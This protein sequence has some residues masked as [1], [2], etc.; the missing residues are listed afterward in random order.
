MTMS[1]Y[2]NKNE[3]LG[4]N[5][6]FNFIT[7]ARGIGKTYQFKQWAIADHIRTGATCWWVMRYQTEIDT[8]IKDGRFFADILDRFPGHVFK[9]DGSVGYIGEGD[10]PKETVWVPFITFKALSE[11]AIKAISDPQCNKMVFDEFIPLPGIRYLKNE[12]ERFLELY[13]TISRGRDL[14]TFFLANN[15]TSVCP[16][17]TYFK[18]KP[19]A[20]E[21]TI[22][23]DICIQNA[24]TQA[25]TE[26]MRETRFGKLVKGTHYADY[27]IENQSLADTDAFVLPMPPRHN[28]IFTIKTEYGLF[29]GY[30]C[31]P[32]MLYIKKAAGE[33]A[34]YVYVFDSTLH[35]DKTLLDF[36]GKYVIDVIRSYYSRGLI[37]FPNVRD[38]SEFFQSTAKYLKI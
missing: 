7:G 38:K 20:A 10:N 15:V 5:K 37:G 25:F 19:S 17:Y 23:G 14:R 1:K 29:N 18:V 24:R 34:D 26:S 4:Y 6:L 13:F 22:S 31:S 3:L 21:F 9:I 33:T 2:Y 32:V 16:Y 27:A 35:D 11:S 30:M 12:V 28:M 8:I 36:R